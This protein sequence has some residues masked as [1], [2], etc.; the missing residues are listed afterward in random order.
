MADGSGFEVAQAACDGEDS[1]KGLTILLKQVLSDLTH[2]VDR[3]LASHALT[4]AK[5]LPLIALLD[6]Q[7]HTTSSIAREVRCDTG[8][9]TRIISD[10]EDKGLI[11]RERSRDDR[12]VV[13][14]QLTEA[15]HAVARDVPAVLHEVMEANLA[16]LA[17]PERQML[18]GLLRRVCA[19]V[20]TDNSASCTEQVGHRDKARGTAP[21]GDQQIDRQAHH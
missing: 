20:D 10:L 2:A 18:T 11:T 7:R 15:G 3:T 21:V 1:F 19:K 17:M 8:A 16:C 13:Y 5:S 12:R 14:L 6:G 4:F 9:M